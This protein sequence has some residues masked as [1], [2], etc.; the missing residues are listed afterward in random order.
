MYNS[1]AKLFGSFKPFGS[2]II[3]VF[4]VLYGNLTNASLYVFV[5]IGILPC[6]TK[7]SDPAFSANL[8]SSI[9][10]QCEAFFMP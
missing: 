8:D 7:A 4:G 1:S 9:A 3:S 10:S 2:G 5:T 6:L